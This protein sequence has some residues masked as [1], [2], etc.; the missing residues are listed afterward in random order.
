MAKQ[1]LF[2]SNLLS[3]ATA[4]APALV[5]M[6]TMRLML[7]LMMLPRLL[8]FETNLFVIFNKPVH[9]SRNF[10]RWHAEAFEP[11]CVR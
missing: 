7:L 11:F 4:S 9:D 6:V 8:L 10:I 2:T 5:V 3:I 1:T